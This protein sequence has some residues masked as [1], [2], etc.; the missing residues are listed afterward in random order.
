MLVTQISKVHGPAENLSSSTTPI[1]VQG[2]CRQW[3]AVEKWT[4]EWF[5]EM[6]GEKVV[7]LTDN[8]NAPHQLPIDKTKATLGQYLDN[9]KSEA[10]RLYIAGLPYKQYFPDLNEDVRTLEAFSDNILEEYVKPAVQA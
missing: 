2:G 5:K 6:H 9:L 1:L 3:P 10:T 4:K 8:V 7:P